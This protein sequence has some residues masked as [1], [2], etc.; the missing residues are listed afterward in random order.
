MIACR[1]CGFESP[2]D[3]AFCPKC[4][5]ALAAC[6]I[7]EERKTVTTL[8]CDL[9]AFTAMSEVGDP[10]DVDALLGEYFSRATK[11]IESH[12]GTVEKFIGDAVVGVF[13]VPAA[14]EDDPERAVRAG[15]RIVAALDGMTRPDGSPLQVRCGVNTGEALVRLD[16]N[17]ASGRGFLTGDAVNVAA[18][19]EAAAPPGGVAVGFTTHQ[20]SAAAILYADLPPVVAKGKT[21]PV[22]AWCAV[23]PV[24]RRTINLEA[25]DLS[26]LVGRKVE[27]AGL[28]ATLEQALTH[29]SPR[30]VLL[31]GEPGIGKSRLVRELLA[32]VDALPTLTTWRQ[33]YCPSF[34]ENVTYSALSDVVKRHAGILDTDDPDVIEAKLEAVVPDGQEAGW[35]AARLRALVGLEA[36]DA[37]REENFAAWLRFFE[38]V[39][40]QRPTV[41]VFE[42]LHWADEALLA[43]LEHLATSITDVPLLVVGTARTE[44]FEREPAFAASPEVSRIDLSPLT[45]AE[46]VRLVA[47]VLGDQAPTA[48]DEVVRRCDGNPFFAE[49]SARYLLDATPGA[50]LPDSVQAVIA[51][52]LDSLSP[53]EKALLADAAV[54]GAVFWDGGLIALGG[55]G[56]EATAEV[57]CAL[58]ERRFV[59][60]VRESSMRGAHEYSF[61]HALARE[62]A[63]AQ[64]PKAVRARKHQ[65]VAE[66][67]E[68]QGDT[69]GSTMAE[70]VAYHLA[71]AVDLLASSR[72]G[73]PG[74][75]LRD[76]AVMW[77]HAAAEQAQAVDVSAARRHY[78]RALEIGGRE[79]PASAELLLGLGKALLV[80]GED[81]A[82]ARVLQEAVDVSRA[83]EHTSTLL[84]ALRELSFALRIVGR[85]QPELMDQAL[86]VARDVGSAEDLIR[87]LPSWGLSKV[88]FEGDTE[89]ALEAMEEAFALSTAHGLEPTPSL[90][91]TRGE[92]LCVC[93]QARGLDD[94]RKALSLLESSAF[95]SSSDHSAFVSD[96]VMVLGWVEGPQ[97]SLREARERIESCEHRGMHAAV[98]FIGNCMLEDR[99]VAGDWAT[100]LADL[101]RSE[102]GQA[103]E[104]LQLIKA[105]QAMLRARTGNLEGLRG[106]LAEVEEL[107]RSVVVQ[108][109]IVYMTVARAAGELALGD[110]AEATRRLRLW[111]S[112]PP[113]SSS[114]GNAWMVP[115]ATRIALACGVVDVAEA[116]RH[117]VDGGLPIQQMAAQTVSCLLADRSGALAEASTG[118]AVV[119]RRWC[120]FG[121]HYEEA[122]ALLGQGRCLVALG[123]APEAAAPLAAAREIFAHLGAKP[124]LDE[125][126]EWLTRVT[127]A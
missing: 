66:W 28:S 93:G 45:S 120:E 100:L 40:T 14:H 64:L 95:W 41:L 97:A 56:Q 102:Q 44:L 101:A 116:L 30:F 8:F 4:A 16:V 46:T 111:A 12:G 81:E 72:Q 65:A 68:S 53:V 31:V 80:T 124:A 29:S 5:T 112:A 33:G 86:S 109:M 26:P 98:R 52:R 108:D 20:L 77:L 103:T 3:F 17:P 84:Q 122:H 121:V 32:Y 48:V 2:D 60:R 18:R 49:Q 24:S 21:E 114:P 7:A 99:L 76:A 94:F 25:G 78:D 107:E 123:R 82:G 87:C 69:R 11:V 83:H 63:Y 27:L 47:Q 85:P 1:K 51:A 38:G 113:S 37:S 62:V 75:E 105:L 115:D 79:H 125:T 39:A 23:A 19:L 88:W 73:P 13:G 119:A 127:T 74:R 35:L 9:V 50:A 57:L 71:V 70:L 55:R 59:R 92:L 15:L 117:R 58:L 34:G 110:T 91:G 104:D 118:F 67:L 96:Y 42:D 106:L 61:V 6:T 36:P 126:E 10:E 54:M 89:C 43:F 22:Q 90:L